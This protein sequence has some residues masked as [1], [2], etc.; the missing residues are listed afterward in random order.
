MCYNIQLLAARIKKSGKRKNKTDEEIDK[1]M[2]L[3]KKQWEGKPMFSLYGFDFPSLP[4]IILKETI[5]P[6]DASWGLIPQWCTDEEKQR[7]LRNQTLNARIESIREK[8]AFKQSFLKN[9]CLIPVTGYYEYKHFGKRAIPHFIYPKNEES[10]WMAGI[11]E[12]INSFKG[13]QRTFSIVTTK[14]NQF[15]AAIH[16]QAKSVDGPRMPLMLDFDTAEHWLTA[17][18]DKAYEIALQIKTSEDYLSAHMVQPLKGPQS[19]GNVSTASEPF[20]YKDLL[21]QGN[22]FD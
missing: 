18:P 10:L 1:A 3:I 7:M 2:E 11:Y 5:E 22:L 16:N 20:T 19:P 4:I 9:R 15:T 13:I 17:D 8:P 6:L 12:E 14:A 21:I